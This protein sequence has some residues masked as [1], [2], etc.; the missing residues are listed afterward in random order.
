VIPPFTP[1]R[2]SGR[3]VDAVLRHHVLSDVGLLKQVVSVRRPLLAA[4]MRFELTAAGSEA[5]PRAQGPPRI[6]RKEPGEVA[7][8]ARWRAGPLRAEVRG[9]FEVDGMLLVELHLPEQPEVVVERL[10]LVVPLRSEVATLMN[11]VTDVNG[12]NLAGEVP[13]GRGPVW[14]SRRAQRVEL[15]GNLVP[16]VWLGDEERGLAW[17]AAG[18]R[19]WV[20]DPG[21]SVQ[22]VERGSQSVDLRVRLVGRPQVLSHARRLVFGLQATPTKPAA[23]EPPW[24]LWQPRCAAPPPIRSLCI[25]TASLAWG[26]ATAFGDFY[27]AAGN[28]GILDALGAARRTG[29]VARGEADAWLRRRSVRHPSP[30]KERR[31]LDYGFR[32][33]AARPDAVVAYVNSHRVA[34]I[35][36]FEIYGDEWSPTPFADRERPPLALDKLH[37]TFPTRSWQDFALWHLQRLL[38]SG[39][40]DGFYFDL[41]APRAIFDDVSGSAYRDDDGTL[42]PAVDI[43]E[44]R[45]FLRR[46]QVMAYRMQGR[47]LNVSHMTNAPVAPIHTWSAAILDGELRYGPEPFPQRFSRDW[48]RA[49]SLGTQVGSLPLFLPGVKGVDSA[50]RRRA[51]ERSVVA[52]TAVHEIRVFG[53]ANKP[54]KAVWE[55]LCRFGFGRDDCRVLPFW[56]PLYRFGYGR[57][58]CRVLR[59]WDRPR[60]FRLSGVDAEALVLV[61]GQRAL[62]LVASFGE[63]GTGEL[64]LDGDALGLAPGGRCRDARSKRPIGSAGAFTCRFEI[65]SFG[66]HLITWTED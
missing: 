30:E 4:P 62:A 18:T 49:E 5:V 15:P 41:A 24:R 52:G 1:L 25:L 36:E 50:E 38:Q 26:G 39:V 59:Y 60:H 19:D 13:S 42:Q 66:L 47:W 48:L 54:A 51:I 40:A 6:T 10:D 23:L 3:E 57:D 22:T 45:E 64:A 20:L 2:V 61:R 55:L 58:D 34:P 35:P 28:E 44:L 31:G 9:R 29:R 11:A 65:P 7:Y 33:L 32:V 17:F 56:D 8:T 63:G 46:A 21:A 12:H 14:D 27:P 53:G 43:L 16:Y 37:R